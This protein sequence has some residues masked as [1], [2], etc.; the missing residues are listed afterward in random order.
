[1]TPVFLA[2]VT[3]LS[4]LA[5]GITAIKNLKRLHYVLGF[6]AGVI[7][8]VIAFDLLPEIFKLTSANHIDPTKPMIALVIGFLLF[9]IF[10]KGL[11]IHH[12]HEHE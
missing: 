7:L 11:L 6:T 5:G 10:E 2:I 3:F 1:M 4:T 12:A 9:H 8:G